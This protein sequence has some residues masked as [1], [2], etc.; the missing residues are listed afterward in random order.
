MA[1][2]EQNDSQ[3]ANPIDSQVLASVE[4]KDCGSGPTLVFRCPS[5]SEEDTED[6]METVKQPHTMG[7]FP[8]WSRVFKEMRHENELIKAANVMLTNKQRLT[9]KQAKAS[10][11]KTARMDQKVSLIADKL[12]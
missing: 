9:V 10:D 7:E 8:A 2:S 3:V 1:T 6:D 5:D 12:L 4:H 11:R